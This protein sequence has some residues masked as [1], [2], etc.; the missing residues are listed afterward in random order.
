[1]LFTVLQ[2]IL[3][4]GNYMNSS[5]KKPANGFK[6]DSLAKIGETRS[7]DRQQTLLSYIT[8]VVE[9]VYPNVLT[10]YDDLEVQDACNG[11]AIV[12]GTYLHQ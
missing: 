12:G 11:M 7:Q 9:K 6:L 8:H 5:R 4:F 1:M 2:V 3:A 10:F